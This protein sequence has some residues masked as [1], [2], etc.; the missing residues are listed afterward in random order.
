[1]PGRRTRLLD[2]AAAIAAMEKVSKRI[3]RPT[4]PPTEG[5]RV[6]LGLRV[7]ADVKRK[8]DEA[9]AKSGRSQSQEAELRL[10]R[11]FE[12][13]QLFAEIRNIMRSELSQCL[14]DGEIE[15]QWRRLKQRFASAQQM[16]DDRENSDD[17]ERQSHSSSIRQK[18]LSTPE[19]TSR[20]A[21]Q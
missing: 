3:G 16:L 8:L 12:R 13:D 18:K 2:E 21:K 9:A 17:S 6:S 14:M 4:K 19:P 7:T 11:S 5:E 10:E 15:K 1:M 20:K